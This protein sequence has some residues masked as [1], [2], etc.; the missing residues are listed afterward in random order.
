MEKR[1]HVDGKGPKGGPRPEGIPAGERGA[2]SGV[3][4]DRVDRVRARL[5]SGFYDRPEVVARTALLILQ[6]GDLR[7]AL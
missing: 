6:S 7:G 4:A 1:M 5:R 3:G 2:S